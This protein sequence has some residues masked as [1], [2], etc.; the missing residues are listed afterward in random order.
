MHMSPPTT[1]YALLEA[2]I[3]THSFQKG[4]PRL[5]LGDV[6]AEPL[7]HWASPKGLQGLSS[8][9]CLGVVNHW[10]IG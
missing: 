10:F 5:V 9:F 3:V 8:G 4:A 6:G 2:R 1:T 7:S